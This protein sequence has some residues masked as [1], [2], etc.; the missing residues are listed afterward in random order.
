MVPIIEDYAPVVVIEEWFGDSIRERNTNRSIKPSLSLHPIV[1]MVHVCPRLYITEGK[2]ESTE[3]RHN[4]NAA[5]VCRK[6]FDV[7]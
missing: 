3:L 1:G 2:I 5:V 4:T 6:R 7:H